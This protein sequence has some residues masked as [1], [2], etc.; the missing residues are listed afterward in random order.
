MEKGTRV[1]KDTELYEDM[2]KQR[3]I[4]TV[5]VE[6]NLAEKNG[7]ATSAPEHWSDQRPT[8]GGLKE[9]KSQHLYHEAPDC[10]LFNCI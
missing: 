1:M 8:M 5:S 6:S 9:K 7:L 3:S 10:Y 4:P 2:K